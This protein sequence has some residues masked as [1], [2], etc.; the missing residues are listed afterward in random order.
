MLERRKK[1]DKDETLATLAF[2][3]LNVYKEFTIVRFTRLVVHS[4]CLILD[5]YKVLLLKDD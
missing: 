5:H 1:R 3:F 4:F 2:S